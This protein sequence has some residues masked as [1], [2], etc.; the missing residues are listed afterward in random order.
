MTIWMIHLLCLAL[1][2]SSDQPLEIGVITPFCEEEP[3]GKGVKCPALD[4]TPSMRGANCASPRPISPW[5]LSKLGCTH[6]KVFLCL[7]SAIFP[8]PTGMSQGPAHLIPVSVRGQAG[9]QGPDIWSQRPICQ[10]LLPVLWQEVSQPSQ[11]YHKMLAWLQS[12]R[13]SFRDGTWTFLI[14]QDE[15]STVF[16][17]LNSVFSFSQLPSRILE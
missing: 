8:I 14:S 15:C 5:L 16:H 4:H 12:C 3:E 13:Y 7:T 17:S 9:R 11:D 6:T 2:Q 10:S 1:C